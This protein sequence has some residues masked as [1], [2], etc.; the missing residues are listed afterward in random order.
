[1]DSATG[2]QF[3][4]RPLGTQESALDSRAAPVLPGPVGTCRE[5]QAAGLGTELVQKEGQC[6]QAP[7]RLWQL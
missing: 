7:D 5:A 6:G 2:G 4:V 1:M 3:Q